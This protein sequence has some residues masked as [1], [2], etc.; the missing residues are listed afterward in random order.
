MDQELIRSAR[1]NH[2]RAPTLLAAK[3][4]RQPKPFRRRIHSG[5]QLSSCL[6]EA[7]DS[8]RGLC[9]AVPYQHSFVVLLLRAVDMA[10][11]VGGLVRLKRQ[12]GCLALRSALVPG[13]SLGISKSSPSP[14]PAAPGLDLVSSIPLP[15]LAPV[16]EKPIRCHVCVIVAS[17]SLGDL[18]LDVCFLNGSFFL[19]SLF[20]L[21]GSLWSPRPKRRGMC[22][23]LRARV[24][25]GLGVSMLIASSDDA[26]P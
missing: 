7:P 11:S 16:L 13:A 17:R 5:H 22:G 4:R 15:F 10:L 24:P 14:L 2:P 23:S 19:I 12:P 9:R 3:R 26:S 18:T 6:Q 21:T 8:Q 20:V 1:I 25:K